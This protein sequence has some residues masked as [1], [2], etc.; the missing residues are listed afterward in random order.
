M[1]TGR[2]RIEIVEEPER[3]P[4]MWAAPPV[5]REVHLA[6]DDPAKTALLSAFQLLSSRGSGPKAWA[7]SFR[8]NP[9][10][11]L[12][13]TSSDAVNLWEAG[14]DLLYRN[15]AVE[16]LGLGRCDETAWEVLTEGPRHLERRC[17]RMRWG[18]AD[19]L[20]EIIGEGSEQAA[21]EASAKAQT[22]L[23]ADWNKS[24]PGSRF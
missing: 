8:H 2:W 7:A 3:L 6:P 22:A 18:K 9:I 12:L 5:R 17:C 11:F 16:R 24:P 20:L 14:G 13:D 10:A 19:Y 1:G 21:A 4:A 15:R 23:S